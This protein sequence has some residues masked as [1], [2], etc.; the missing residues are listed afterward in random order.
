M[1]QTGPL[2]YTCPFHLNSSPITQLLI[3]AAHFLDKHILKPLSFY[4]IIT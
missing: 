1:F 4:N 3:P 2:C